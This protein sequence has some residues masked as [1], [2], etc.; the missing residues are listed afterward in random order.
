MFDA[1]V[2][3]GGAAGMMAAITAAERGKHVLLLEK[4]AQLG[5]KI[6]I[7]GKGRCNVTNNCEP[8]TVIESTPGNGRF[9]YGAVNHFTPQDTMDFFEGL[10][11]PLK[12]ERG[13]RVFPV[14]DNAHDIADALW[15]KLKKCRVEIRQGNV[16]EVL[17]ENGSV[18]GVRTENDVFEAPSVLLACGGASYPG[19]GSNGDGARLAEKL[20]HTI[21][22]MR[23]SL[24]ALTSDDED[25]PAMQGLSLRNCGVTVTDNEKKK[26]PVYTDF[27]ELLF[28][29]FGLSGPTILSASAHMRHMAPGRYTVTLDL[30]PALTPEQLDQRLLRDLEKNK[31]RNFSNSLDELLPQ[32]MIPVV[33]RR[34]GIP[35]E[36]KCNTITRE[37]RAVLLNVLKHFTVEI[38]G[39]APLSVPVLLLG[40]SS[41]IVGGIFTL[42]LKQGKI[43]AAKLLP[44]PVIRI[45]LCGSVLAMFLLLSGHGRY[46]GLGT[47]LIALACDGGTIYWFDFLCKLLFTVCTLAIGF[48]GGEVT[49]LF[50]IGACLGAA[51]A[52][53][54]GI[55]P[56]FAAALCYAAV[57][58]SASN[59]WLAPICIGT[60]VFGFAY[61]P[62]FAVV[63]TVSRLC[64][65][66]RSM[67]GR[68]KP[69][70]LF[71]QGQK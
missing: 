15:K 7:T 42:L 41:G 56:V 60:E 28:T 57:F 8:R 20:G 50:A 29:H 34:S 65:G 52:P 9:L 1:V 54:F 4:N 25:C 13:N 71:L 14:S 3:G 47:D 48:Q 51:L 44:N 23:P 30:K 70:P 63:C 19:T 10:G 43:Y 5:R 61:L 12:T 31:N 39:F 58:G 36:E 46:A 64:N 69:A 16:K 67:Y 62:Y 33:V 2:V 37:Q 21:I 22:P 68:Q 32:K 59:T 55:S 27:G 53:L 24:V 18:I 35:P 6:R 45:A 66:N 49:P 40:I 26:K 38:S 11:V 17:T